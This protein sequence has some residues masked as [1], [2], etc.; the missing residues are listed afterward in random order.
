VS[1]ARCGPNVFGFTRAPA[2]RS[3]G[4]DNASIVGCPLREVSAMT[5][6]EGLMI[7]SGSSGASKAS[8]TSFGGRR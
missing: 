5:C 8:T 2:S 6:R 4:R 7:A 3:I 1:P